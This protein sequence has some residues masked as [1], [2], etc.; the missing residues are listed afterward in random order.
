MVKNAPANAGDTGLVPESGNNITLTSRVMTL[1]VRFSSFSRVCHL[2][3]F[4]AFGF[5]IFAG[6]IYA[7]ISLRSDLK[8]FSGLL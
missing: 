6:C 2:L 1:D 5:I 7:K 4:I 8:V 3:L